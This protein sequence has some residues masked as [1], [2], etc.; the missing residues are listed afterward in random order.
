VRD[1]LREAYNI[2]RNDAKKR[3]IRFEL[4]FDQ[5]LKIWQDSGHLGQ[6]GKNRNQYCMARF[7]D[8][9][10][11]SVDNVEIKTMHDNLTE[12]QVLAKLSKSYSVALLGNKNGVGN[13]G[14]KKNF[15]EETRAYYRRRMI[16]NKFGCGAI[17]ID[18]A[19]TTERRRAAA[20]ERDKRDP[21]PR[22][23]SGRYVSKRN[24]SKP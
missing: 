22:G 21:Q 24:Q 6:R 18:S 13:R 14:K 10:P 4:T 9:G 20:I 1:K 15:S 3:G 5:W 2:H 16:G 11:Y 12:P 23:S 19:E 17:H 7:G 8:Q